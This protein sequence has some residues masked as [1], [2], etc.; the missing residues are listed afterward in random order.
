M[1]TL[2]LP[3]TSAHTCTQTLQLYA[4]LRRDVLNFRETKHRFYF[5]FIC[6]YRETITFTA[7]EN[8]Y[9]EKSR[10]TG[11]WKLGNRHRKNALQPQQH[12]KLVD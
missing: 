1:C 9:G 4:N 6:I 5:K 8:S 3:N 12:S 2:E 11:K 10:G 7:L